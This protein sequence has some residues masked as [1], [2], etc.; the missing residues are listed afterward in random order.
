MFKHTLVMSLYLLVVGC[1][2]LT[3]EQRL[4]SDV[5]SLLEEQLL[6]GEIANWH[7]KDEPNIERYLAVFITYSQANQVCRDYFTRLE[8]NGKPQPK[9]FGTSCRL[10]P[11]EWEPVQWST[12][13][14]PKQSSQKKAY[15]HY[16]QLVK[17]AGNGPNPFAT[18]N[19]TLPQKLL[20]STTYAEKKYKVPFR[21]IIGKAAA[22]RKLNP[23]LIHAVVKT[24]SNYNPRAVS[25]VGAKGLM[26]LMPATAKEMGVGNVFNPRENIKGGSGYL[27]KMLTRR[28]I[29]GNVPLALAAYNAGYGNVQKYGYK[30]PPFKETL[31]YVKKIM[32]LY[33][34][35]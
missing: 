22:E 12:H 34:A 8:I 9:Q 18:G 27:K 33:K 17:L 3:K 19:Y 16:Q 15:R 7:D 13:A 31:N 23:V 20:K 35:S 10:A 30:V 25:H 4:T 32:A 21:K 5:N 11:H 26:Q 24:E 1:I 6:D 2:P 28:G 29:N 14:P